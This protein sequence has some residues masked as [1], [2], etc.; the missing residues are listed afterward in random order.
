[1]FKNYLKTTLRNLWRNKTYSFLNIFGLSIGITCAALIFLWVEDELHFDH[2]NLKINRIY[3]VMENQ[4]YAGKTYTFAATPGPLAPAMKLEIPGVVN[5]TRM[6]WNQN[7]LFSLGDK[8]LYEE[9]VYIDSNLFNIFTIPFL[10]GN[11]S[12]VFSQQNSLI[13]TE[14]MARKF[15]PDLDHQRIVGKTLKIDNKEDFLITAVIK[16]LPENSSIKF[17]WAAPYEVYHKTNNW[18][19]EW[20]NNGIQT[21]IELSQTTSPLTVDKKIYGYIQSK[22][23]DAV[24]RLFLNS[25]HDWR[26]RSHFEEG[27]RV[28]GRYQYVRMFTIIAWIILLIACINFMNLATARSEKRAREVGVRK[29]LGAE[30]R[31]LVIQ[32][33]GEAMFMSLLA[34]LFSILL[35]FILLPSFNTLVEKQLSLG[36]NQP[37]HLLALLSIII[38]CGLVAGSY[39][40]LYLSSFNPVTVFKGLKIKGGSASL[41]RK[42]LVILQF[43]I[44]I[45]LIISTIIIFQQ[46][47]HVKNREL[48][49]NKDNL[50]QTNVQG[51]MVKHFAS[52][53]QDL[54]GTGAVQDVSLASLGMLWMGSSTSNLSWQGKDPNKKILITTDGVDPNY[55]PTIGLKI[56]QGRNF[57]PV[58]EQD[59]MSFII[60]ETLAKMMGMANPIGQIIKYDTVGYKVVGVVKDFVYGDMYGKSDPLIFFCKPE[61]ADYVYIKVK[62]QDKME[63]ALS[64]IEKVMKAHNPGYP[65]DYRFV[66][67]DFNNQFKIEALI[68]K[69]SR[70]F[71]CLAIVISCLGLFGLAAYTAERRTR[72]IGIRKVLGAT[73]PR[74]TRL[75]SKD[76]L[77]LVFISALVAFPVSWYAMHTWLQN[78]AYRITINWWVFIV[79]GLLAIIIALLTISFQAIKAALTS[80]VKNLR[81]E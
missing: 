47:Q 64:K 41:I 71:A 73:V 65:F 3:Q 60:N 17:S 39:P 29:V 2:Y 81:T 8:A 5:S 55:I 70:V 44:S 9:G 76:F 46:I 14:K 12:T 77:Q 59:S 49:Y 1:M 45:V 36:L 68:G 40:A 13:L 21:F 72:E 33:I 52:V 30:K 63:A 38:V 26:L 58:A 11:M 15:F 27:K 35:L 16:D 66:D 19:N 75:L 51:E 53:R 50:L 4:A 32:F 61:W 42:G 43:T 18:L 28:G 54:I 48:G 37:V 34:V 22:A 10:E 74:I 31:M 62:A 79:A 57:L 24:P 78:Y 20:G 80:P 25:M 23:K 6:T 69:L 67:E 56:I 7:R